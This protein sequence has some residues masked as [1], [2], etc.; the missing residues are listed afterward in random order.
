MADATF[1]KF[2]VHLLP[3]LYIHYEFHAQIPEKSSRNIVDRSTA[4][5]LSSLKVDTFLSI[6]WL[7][8]AQFSWGQ[9]LLTDLES[10][11]LPDHLR[12]ENLTILPEKCGFKSSCRGAEIAADQTKNVTPIKWPYLAHTWGFMQQNLAH[13]NH[14]SSLLYP[15]GN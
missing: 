13:F 15:I 9:R 7:I 5:W 4:A 2:Y 11:F 14:W 1:Y 6:T 8:V 12:I 10:S 3:I